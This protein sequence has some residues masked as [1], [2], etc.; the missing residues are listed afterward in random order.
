M[1]NFSA[2]YAK[3]SNPHIDLSISERIVFAT[4]TTSRT[5]KRTDPP[6]YHTSVWENVGFVGNA[7]EPAKAFCGGEIIDIVKGS[8]IREKNGRG[9]YDFKQTVFEFK[10]S[11][12]KR[13]K[14]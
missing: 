9:E 4:L 5:D 8:Q 3:V 12:L 14:E 6:T 2:K 13:N 1:N 11:E 7:F 10:L